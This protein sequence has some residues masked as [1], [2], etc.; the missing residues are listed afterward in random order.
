MMVSK[1]LQRINSKI[2]T[3]ERN[4]KMRSKKDVSTEERQEI[5]DELRL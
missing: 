4:K 3:Y 1:N 2:V 5:I